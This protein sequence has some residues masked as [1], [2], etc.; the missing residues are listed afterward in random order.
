L[1]KSGTT[2]ARCAAHDCDRTAARKRPA[3]KKRKKR[4]GKKKK[5]NARA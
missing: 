3:G 4:K 1:I 5:E 2:G